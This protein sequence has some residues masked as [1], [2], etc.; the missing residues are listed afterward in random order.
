MDLLQFWWNDIFGRACCQEEILIAKS[1]AQRTPIAAVS[2]TCNRNT[3]VP[4]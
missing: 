1:E 4:R 2:K 3:F